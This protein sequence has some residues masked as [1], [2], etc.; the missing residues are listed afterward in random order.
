[1]ASALRK[2]SQRL[3]RH[4]AEDAHGQAGAGERLAQ[5]NFLRQAEFEPEL[6]HFVLEQAFQRLDELELHFLRQAA[7][8]V[9]A[10]DER[11]GIAGDGHGFDHV[12]IKR[13]LREK[14]RLA[15]A[16]GRRLKNFDERPA[17]DFAFAF[18]VG[19][20]FEPFQKQFR[21]VLVLQFDFENAGRKP[22]APTSASRA[23]SRPLLTKMQVSWS[24][25]ALCS[26]A[27]AT[28]E[29]TPPLKPRMTFPCRP[30]R[31]FPRRPARRNCASS[32]FCRSRRRRGRN[33]K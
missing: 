8:V 14:F 7:D 30:A 13:A 27:A 17:D 16:L 25:M 3:R 33:W 31:G 19:H 4:F 21:G 22:P 28:L 9:M 2:I 6:A 15:G 1:M 26:S 23:R 18:R 20:A 11:G 10:L 5:D 32:S 24:P 29:S 12:G